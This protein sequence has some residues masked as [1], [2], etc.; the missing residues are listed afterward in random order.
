MKEIIVFSGAKGFR[1][2]QQNILFIMRD[3]LKEMLTICV[4]VRRE[5]AQNYSYGTNL[6][7]ISDSS[8]LAPFFNLFITILS[9]SD[10]LSTRVMHFK[11]LKQFNK[12]IT[13]TSR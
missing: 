8:P 1:N 12:K 13:K 5:H 10:V 4:F 6:Q 3:R 9:A 2:I 7:Y 11:L